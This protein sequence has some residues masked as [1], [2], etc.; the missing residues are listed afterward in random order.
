MHDEVPEVIYSDQKRL[1]QILFNLVGNAV[2]FTYQ[3]EIAIEF[4]YE[5]V[6]RVLSGTV[7][8]T[9]VG[10]RQEDMSKLFK[11]FGQIS[12]TKDI[13]KSGMG[14]GLTISKMIIQQLG[15]EINLQSK[16]G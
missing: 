10:I 7:R 16:E 4:R 15:G 8:D 11:F 9:G 14:L 13:N 1:K 5:A 3:G 6:Q 12:S 2:K